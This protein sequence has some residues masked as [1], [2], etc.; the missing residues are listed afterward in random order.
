M[1]PATTAVGTGEATTHTESC[2]ARFEEFFQR[3]EARQKEQ[4]AKAAP[5]KDEEAAPAPAPE[6]QT[7]PPEADIG[8][9]EA[10]EGLHS[11]PVEEKE[12]AVAPDPMDE[13]AGAAGRVAEPPAAADETRIAFPLEAGTT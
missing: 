13:G 11:S 1:V 6:P 7:P 5:E 10:Q 9:D 4:Q 8:M 12:T 3:L 2:R